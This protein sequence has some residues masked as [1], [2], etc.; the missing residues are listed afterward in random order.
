MSL[1]AR[2]GISHTRPQYPER[3]SGFNSYFC[4]Y[5]YPTL[6]IVGCASHAPYRTGSLNNI[7]RS[8]TSTFFLLNSDFQTCLFCWRF[9]ASDPFRLC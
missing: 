5:N 6:F 9:W 8:R 4:T 7:P 1:Q 2:W 3:A